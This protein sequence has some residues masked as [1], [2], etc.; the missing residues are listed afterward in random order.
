MDRMKHRCVEAK[1]SP[2]SAGIVER[3]EAIVTDSEN[4]YAYS[5][6]LKLIDFYLLHPLNEEKYAQ[7]I[8]RDT[9]HWRKKRKASDGSESFFLYPDKM[10]QQML[11]TSGLK[12]NICFLYTENATKKALVDMDLSSSH[13]C[14]VHPRAVLNM[15]SQSKIV[16]DDDGNLKVETTNAEPGWRCFFRHIRNAFAHNNVSFFEN[17]TVLLKDFQ[18]NNDKQNDKKM[19]AA[20]LIRFDTLFE[21]IQ[22][23]ETDQENN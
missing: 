3:F 16:E 6:I 4:R 1:K 10:F 15:N 23:I 19:T 18:R 2:L 20:I 9:F 22:M 11:E 17:G 21:W 5:D 12:D 8:L 7:E 14:P 13:I